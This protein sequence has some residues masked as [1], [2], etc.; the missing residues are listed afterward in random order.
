M[1]SMIPIHLRLSDL[2]A[3]CRNMDFTHGADAPPLRLSAEA[4]I[5]ILKVFGG[6][7]HHAASQKIYD[8]CTETL[9]SLCEDLNS[10]EGCKGKGKGEGSSKGRS[11]KAPKVVEDI[12]E[13]SGLEHSKRVVEIQ[14]KIAALE[15]DRRRYTTWGVIMYDSGASITD[16]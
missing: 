9:K 12:V 4:K 10:L 14:G 7:H 3:S 15:D 5:S 16:A 11:K 8:E 6:R 1:D 13:G 2:D